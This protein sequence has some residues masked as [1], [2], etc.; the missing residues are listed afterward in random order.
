ME[1]SVDCLQ[2]QDRTLSIRGFGQARGFNILH[3]RFNMLQPRLFLLRAAF[4]AIRMD[5]TNCCSMCMGPCGDIQI[6]E[7]KNTQLGTLK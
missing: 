7:L 3:L 4:W 5:N 1:A 2:S 6:D